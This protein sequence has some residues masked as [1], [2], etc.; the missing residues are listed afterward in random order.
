MMFKYLGILIMKTILFFILAL[1]ISCSGQYSSQIAGY[2]M[3]VY[4]VNAPVAT[5]SYVDIDSVGLNV[6]WERGGTGAYII[7]STWTEYYLGWIPNT[8]DLWD[9]NTANGSQTI[10]FV[11]GYYAVTLTEVDIYN[12]ES[13]KAN[14]FFIQCRQVYARVPINLF[15]RE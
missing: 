8:E 3:Y 11:E 7:D 9:G 14:P 13:P 4:D 6:S 5:T 1:A 10:S 15:R 12:N 2:N